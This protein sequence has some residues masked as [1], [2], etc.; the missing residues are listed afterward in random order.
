MT[1]T[2][3][4]HVINKC[5]SIYLKTISRTCSIAKHFRE[6]NKQINLL[7]SIYNFQAPTPSP[8]SVQGRI[9]SMCDVFSLS[10]CSGTR[11]QQRQC[12]TN[13]GC[14]MT[15]QNGKACEQDRVLAIIEAYSKAYSPIH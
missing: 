15:Y 14:S 4:Q 2:L 9:P 12:F 1:K 11:S 10:C 5:K 8:I 7:T 13:V 6:H 3:A